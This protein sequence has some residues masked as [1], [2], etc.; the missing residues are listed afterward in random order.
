[1]KLIGLT[2]HELGRNCQFYQRIDSTQN[3]MWRLL[4]TKK[5]PNGFLIMADIQTA[6]KGTHGRIWYTDE[7]DNI[8][9]SFLIKPNCQ[10]KK[11]EGIT[12]EIAE[13]IIH[14]FQKEYQIPL[15]IKKPNDLMILDKKVGGILTESKVYSGIAKYL[16]IGIGINTSKMH[17]SED[18]EKTA[19]SI[20]KEFGITIDR[21]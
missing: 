6:G 18:I 12:T 4:E 10:I 20:K 13:C 16:V 5:V 21:I 11:L 15:T 7:K 1:M 19:T 8:A 2:T 3:E 14:L 17:F 9:F